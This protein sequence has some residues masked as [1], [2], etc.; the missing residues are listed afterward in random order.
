MRISAT[1][2]EAFRLWRDSSW[3]DESRLQAQ[4]RGEFEPTHKVLLGKAYGRVLEKPDTYRVAGGYACDGFRFEEDVVAPALREIDRRGIFECKATKR[5][6]AHTVVAK[7]DHLLGLVIT[8]FKTRL[9]EYHAERYAG[10]Y[11]WR[12]MVDLFDAHQVVYQV[13][14][15]AERPLRLTAIEALPL[16]PYPNLR[17]DCAALV[18][19]FVG[20]V[21]R[22]R[23]EAYL[24][25]RPGELEGSTFEDSPVREASPAAARLKALRAEQQRNGRTEEDRPL[26]MKVRPLKPAE[27]VAELPRPSFSLASPSAPA[28]RQPSLF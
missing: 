18:D 3:M 28:P 9:G 24:P 25:D 13:F 22:C 11:Q 21:R 27:P 14:R 15:L 1:T 12:F 6:G 19:E 23:L 8:E 7:A 4:I 5:Y 10:S 17:D 20:Y 2:L 26:P 16:Y